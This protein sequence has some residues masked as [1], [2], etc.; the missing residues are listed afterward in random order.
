MRS[1]QQPRQKNAKTQSNYSN[2]G[3]AEVYPKINLTRVLLE[4]TTRFS[5]QRPP[6][7]LQGACGVKLSGGLCCCQ[8]G[9]GVG[10]QGQTRHVEHQ[11]ESGVERISP[12]KNRGF[13]FLKGV[14]MGLTN[15]QALSR[16]MSRFWHFGWNILMSLLVSKELSFLIRPYYCFFFLHL[17]S[18]FWSL[19]LGGCSWS[20]ACCCVMEELPKIA[21]KEN[22]HASCPFFFCVT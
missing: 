3:E 13:S 17:S 2:L 16:K 4:L 21:P 10:A 20:K 22:G 18:E 15:S 6:W 8:K 5:G 19:K 11:N 1:S 7:R 12:I 14:W 9:A